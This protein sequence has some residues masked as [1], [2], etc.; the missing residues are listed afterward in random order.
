MWEQN[1]FAETFP[2][3]KPST[4]L[5]T[6]KL[7]SARDSNSAIREANLL[8]IPRDLCYLCVVARDQ[9]LRFFQHHLS[10]HEFFRLLSYTASYF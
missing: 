2:V 1:Q 3:A 9:H 10:S 5:G 8:C 4:A 7:I 6:V